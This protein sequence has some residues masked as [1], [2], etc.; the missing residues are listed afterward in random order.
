MPSGVIPTVGSTLRPPLVTD[1]EEFT[2]TL[3]AAATDRIAGSGSLSGATGVGS[4]APG[5]GALDAPVRDSEI[6][7]AG[8]E[9]GTSGAGSVVT[10]TGAGSMGPR[11]LSTPAA[12]AACAPPLR[13]TAPLDASRSGDRG[14][15]LGAAEL[16][17]P[18]V[19]L[20][21]AAEAGPA[22]GAAVP[23][24][25]PES[26]SAHAVEHPETM[27]VPIPSATARPPIRP[28]NCAEVACIR[29]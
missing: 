6:G 27:A 24:E 18:R 14:L 23:P 15:T 3:E 29:T 22:S 28:T 5:D 20:A 25:R 2:G 4:A 7:G 26:V 19:G 17:C 16:P 12:E 8:G 10:G 9:T 21:D 1:C 13:L 11:S